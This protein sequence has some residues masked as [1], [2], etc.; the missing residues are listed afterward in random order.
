MIPSGG[1]PTV[2][3]PAAFGTDP[4]SLVSPYPQLGKESQC[5]RPLPLN[6]LLAD[7]PTTGPRFV[8]VHSPAPSLAL[9]SQPSF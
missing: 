8:A 3:V 5:P 7:R 2:P 6:L 9:I 4:L 1:E